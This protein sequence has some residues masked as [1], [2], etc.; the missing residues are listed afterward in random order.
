MVY[1]DND[2][3]G[4]DLD[5]AL[6]E[7]SGQ[8]RQ[9]ALRFSHEEGRRQCVAAYRLLMHALKTEYGITENVEFGYEVGG[10]PYIEG[11]E[12]IHFN[13]SHCRS[14]VACAIDDKP[15]GVDIEAVRPF[16]DS[17][18]RHVLSPSEYE[19]AIASADPAYEFTRL[20]TMKESLLKLTGRGLR[21]DLKTVLPC[22]DGFF[23][24]TFNIPSSRLICTVCQ[25]AR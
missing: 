17:L 3:Y 14:A 12:T 10:K 22:P 25:S 23:H 15:I 8:R 16:K 11:H 21:A 2:I 24:T 4:F 6:A 19:K 13:L 18:A 5:E 7:I 9:Q 1:I 20:W